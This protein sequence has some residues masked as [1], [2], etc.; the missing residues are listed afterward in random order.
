M[1]KSLTTTER[2]S[3]V[4]NAVREQKMLY[5]W[6]GHSFEALTV[7]I[8]KEAERSITIS[9]TSAFTLTNYFQGHLL[10]SRA[11][12][13]IQSNPFSILWVTDWNRQK[14]FLKNVRVRDSMCS[15]YVSS[16]CRFCALDWYMPHTLCSSVWVPAI[17]IC[18]EFARDTNFFCSSITQIVILILY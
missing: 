15:N 17:S 10:V 2:F 14:S 16:F 18:Y 8:S 6:S 13:Q 7:H 11:A 5:P 12:F 1:T 4:Q 3:T 9:I